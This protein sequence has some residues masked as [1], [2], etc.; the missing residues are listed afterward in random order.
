[1]AKRWRFSIRSLLIGFVLVGAVAA[2]YGYRWRRIEL[3]NDFVDAAESA[4]VDVEVV[5]WPKYKL[6]RFMQPSTA[7]AVS[8]RCGFPGILSVE[9][10]YPSEYTAWFEKLI[11]CGG[12]EYVSFTGSEFGREHIDALS[13]LDT[14]KEMDFRSERLASDMGTSLSQ[15]RNIES[16]VFRAAGGVSQQTIQSI[17]QLPSLSYLEIDVDLETANR[18][19]DF[20]SSQ[21]MEGLSLSMVDAPQSYPWSVFSDFPHLERLELEGVSTDANVEQLVVSGAQNYQT[22]ITGGSLD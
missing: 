18:F 20:Q 11:D 3:V 1:M 15:M 12:A 16:L 22:G 8:R 17:S 4:D 7:E 13:R 19:Q 5:W 21:S 10:E 2:V 14:V 6:L 9:A